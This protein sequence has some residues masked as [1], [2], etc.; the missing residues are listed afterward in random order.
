MYNILV[1]DETKFDKSKYENLK[2][3]N[4]RISKIDI[5]DSRKKLQKYLE[6]SKHDLIIINSNFEEHS[7][8]VE[9]KKLF[10]KTKSTVIKSEY[11]T[12][13][14][15]KRLEKELQ[16]LLEQKTCS[17]TD[18]N[19]IIIGSSTG[20]PKA[21]QSVLGR[22]PNTIKGTIIIVQHMPASFTNSL[23]K[24]LNANSIVQVKEIEKNEILMD[25]KVY[26]APGDYHLEIEDRRGKLMPRLSQGKKHLGLRP[27]V[28]LLMLSAAKLDKYDKIGLIL[29]GMGK[30][31][32]KGMKA[33][34]KSGAYNM[35]Q[36][37]ESSVIYGM[38]SAAIDSGAV[39]EI[40]DLSNIP[41][42]LIKR[43]GCS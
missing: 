38:P 14:D 10:Y 31:G 17:R 35:V 37:K 6:T 8:V 26:I 11:F 42:E 39:D 43:V 5:I 9:M 33:L 2:K 29:T 16:V 40:V 22:L 32:A 3:A 24:R 36:D 34:K 18:K 19:L 4:K 15:L 23:S 30:D 7:V 12:F 13:D 41:M 27:A 21:L 20:G 1:Y 28:D 25:G